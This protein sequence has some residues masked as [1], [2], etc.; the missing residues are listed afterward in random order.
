[1][2]AFLII[3][4]SKDI[5]CWNVFFNEILDY[6]K[7]KRFGI[8]FNDR[9]IEPFEHEFKSRLSFSISD[10]YDFDNCDA[11]LKPWWYVDNTKKEFFENM[12][13]IKNVIDICLKYL[14][15]IDVWIGTSGDD[16]SDFDYYEIVVKDFI[17][18]IVR[19]YRQNCCFPPPP[20]I[21]YHIIK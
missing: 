3:S 12:N 18:D 8:F 17:P 16:L 21:H 5:T 10:S 15:S 6:S 1:M 9:F 20:S 4:F 14:D 13:K 7:K 11:I 19:R 2:S